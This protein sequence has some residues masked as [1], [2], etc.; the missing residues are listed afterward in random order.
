MGEYQRGECF[1]R[2]ELSTVSTEMAAPTRWG[3]AGCGKIASDFV[4]AL[5]SNT[6]STTHQVVA[7]A[8]RSLKTAED[9]C[10]KFGISKPVEGYDELVEIP[11]VDVVYVGVIHPYHYQVVKTALSAGK[12]VLCE[13]PLGMNVRE[14]E[15]M[16]QMAKDKGV[17]L[18][19]ATWSR[20][21]PAYA[22][23]RE[24]LDNG[25]IGDVRAVESSFGE[26]FENA[27]ESRICKKS[28]GGGTILDL[29]I[30]C[31]N[32]VTWV[33][34]D[35]TM[36]ESVVAQGQLF[37]GEGT[38]ESVTAMMKFPGKKVA[39][40]STHAMC[41]WQN[42]GQIMGT[43]GR[44][45]LDEP[46]WTPLRLNVYDTKQNLIQTFEFPC[47]D[48]KVVEYNFKNSSNLH[49]QAKHVREC[50]LSGLK[51]SPIHP[52]KATLINAT[53]AETCRKQVGVSYTQD[54]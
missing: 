44:I 48:T 38:D 24:L 34:G 47:N 41:Q 13:K 4:N 16:I 20:F 27:E 6:D 52:H 21:T 32:L 42:R 54:N 43:K 14:T 17:F 40:F 10:E 51:E 33:F 8:A 29:G 36:P 11:D 50:L 9:F 45:E 22:K 30:Y 53:L 46:F 3:I 19:E 25:S 18:M 12:A 15:E 35:D 23:V 28:L 26:E 5:V 2:E 37:E 39:S 31:I 7:A 49:H 1:E